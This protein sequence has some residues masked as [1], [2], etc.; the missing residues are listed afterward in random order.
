MLKIYN[1]MSREKQE[2]KP[3]TPGKIGMYVCGI[4]I[5]D[6]CHIGHG[7]TFVSFD[8]IVRYLRYLGYEVN[9]QRNITD[10]DD[11]IIKRAAE[12]NESCDALTERLTA[13][14][15]KDFDALNMVRPDFEPKATLH[16]PEIIE[17]VQRLL[18]RGHAYVAPD[19]DVLFSVASYKEY[20]RLSGQNID[21]LQ[22]GARVEIDHNKQNPMD[23]VLWKMSKPG[24]PTWESP[25]GAGRPGWHIECSAM[26]GKHLGTHF[27][28]H[29]GGSDLQF[30]HHENEIAQSCCAH[31]TPYVNYWMHTGMVMVDR[32]KM[33]KSLGNF[34]TIRD[35]LKH[36]DA[37]TVRY[38]LLSGH[39]RSQLNYS[40]DNLK[41]A[42]SALER[43][44]TAFKDLDLTVTA[45]PAD[46]YVTKFKSAMNDDFNTPEAYSVLFDMVR[47]I[48][49]LKTT[50]M[51]AASALGVSMKQL[52]D[53]LGIVSVDIE[54]FFKGS[55]SDDEVAEIEALIVE[56]NRARTEK[57]WAAADVARDRLNQLG[58]VLEDGENGTTWKK[59]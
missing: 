54:T 53:V 13:E 22:A 45:A 28:I 12:N 57:D 26:N 35:V 38:F 41:Q 7:R 31:D 52:A 50:D 10:V 48:N 51:G 2:F 11:K 4:T 33:S 16:M 44:Y 46:E 47:E 24:E 58:V 56:R 29:G 27:D 42:R 55:G 34:F 1:S 18:D 43:L 19:G 21:Q 3:I 32:E 40:E 20:G 9:F 5:Y 30:P 8:M 17:M 39:Y 23:F 37:Q 36:Y 14:M 25:W 6:L 15:H 59:K 49:R